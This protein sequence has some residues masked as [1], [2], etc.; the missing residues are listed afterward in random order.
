MLLNTP[1]PE[2]SPYIEPNFSFLK[3][4]EVRI[5]SLPC[6]AQQHGQQAAQQCQQQYLGVLLGRVRL[7]N[8]A[9]NVYRT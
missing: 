2:F 9:E 3:A 8:H 5:L 1:F 7:P 6:A 4:P